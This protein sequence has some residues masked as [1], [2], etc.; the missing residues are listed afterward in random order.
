[1]STTN[2]FRLLALTSIVA[3]LGCKPI[4]DFTTEFVKPVVSFEHIVIQLDGRPILVTGLNH[5]DNN[6][7]DKRCIRIH[8]HDEKLDVVLHLP[9][10]NV[11][12]RWT[13]VKDGMAVLAR[14]PNGELVLSTVTL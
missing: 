6:G 10:R 9:G 5:C 8:P 4:N 7:I 13:L 2:L 12:E 14:R 3:L 1:M 11:Q